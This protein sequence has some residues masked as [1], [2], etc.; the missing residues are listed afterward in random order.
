MKIVKGF[1]L[2]CCASLL[3][4]G[5]VVSSRVVSFAAPS[6]QLANETPQAFYP[7]DTFIRMEFMR[8]QPLPY[9]LTAGGEIFQPTGDDTWQHRLF[10]AAA[11]D[12][13]FDFDGCLS[14]AAEDGVYVAADAAES[15]TLWQ[16]VPDSAASTEI[17]AMHGFTFAFGDSGA[18]RR[19]MDGAWRWLD[20]P[21]DAPA[22]GL[23]MMPDHSH[24]TLNGGVYATHDMGLSWESLNA[25]P[26]IRLIWS[27]GGE[28]LLAVTE[29]LL[30]RW[31][32]RG[33]AWETAAA[34]PDT[35][36]VTAI[37]TF[38]Q[39]LYVVAGE[40]AFRLDEDRWT[41]VEIDGRINWVGVHAERAWL[42]DGFAPAL[43]TSADGETWDMQPIVISS[44][45]PA[46]LLPCPA[47]Q[48][49]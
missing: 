39:K 43:W 1:L 17:T 6:S 4:A 37:R 18:F 38:Q 46:P 8:D 10:P 24:I 11:R 48:E 47:A 41:P 19:D 9:L 3:L 20:M 40:R 27:D 36:P 25:P 49:G 12:L 31:R 15:D 33:R 29:S 13:Y 22:A 7:A 30:L 34:L 26:G 42:L 45:D 16:P 28:N 21:E 35:A 5:A 44:A 32:Y 14:V 23:I 2:I